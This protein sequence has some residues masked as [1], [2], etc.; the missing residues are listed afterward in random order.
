[1][2][3]GISIFYTIELGCAFTMQI[4]LL[5][6]DFLRKGPWVFALRVGSLA[7]L[8]GMQILATKLGLIS[9][10]LLMMFFAIATAHTLMI[11]DILK[12][13]ITNHSRS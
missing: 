9:V 2:T 8:L 13:P 11:Q 3:S 10:A 4:L 5:L 1:M 7:F 6:S 12:E